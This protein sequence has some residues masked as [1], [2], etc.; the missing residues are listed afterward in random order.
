MYYRASLSAVG[1]HRLYPSICDLRLAVRTLVRV[2]GSRLLLF[3]IVDEHIHLVIEGNRREKGA[4]LSALH[5][6]LRTVG[7]DTA[8]QTAWSEKVKTRNHLLSLVD[9]VCRQP[10]RHNLTGRDVLWEGSCLMDL[11]GA[12]S[13]VGY[14]GTLFRT[15]A[16]R[17]REYDLLGKFNIRS[18]KPASDEDIAAAGQ[19][20]LLSA[21]STA[22]CADPKLDGRSHEIVAARAAFVHFGR[23]S[24]YPTKQ[25]ALALGIST[26]GVRHL[27]SINISE[28]HS[29]IARTQLALQQLAQEEGR[30]NFIRR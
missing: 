30:G 14:D 5:R 15:A 26:R 20:S 3:S 23:I 17:W 9:Y 7:K 8:F 21:V 29:R 13:V 22:F 4:V 11:I 10:S 25:L 16:P 24:G 18:L 12:R 1:R 6:S 2:L 27:A 28:A 19:E